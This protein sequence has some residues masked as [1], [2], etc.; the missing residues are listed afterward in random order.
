MVS[1]CDV[2]VSVIEMSC[3][4]LKNVC[5]STWLEYL[6]IYSVSDPTVGVKYNNHMQ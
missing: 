1:S 2:V 4:N 3:I 6:K 5:S